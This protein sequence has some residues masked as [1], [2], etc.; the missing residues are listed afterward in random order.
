MIKLRDIFNLPSTPVDLKEDFFTL[1]GNWVPEIDELVPDYDRE[2]AEAIAEDGRMAIKTV[3][4]DNIDGDRYAMLCTV[5]FD[6]KPT[7]IVQEAGR[8]G[9]D[10]FNRWVVDLMTYNEM[11]S[12]LVTKLTNSREAKFADFVDLD[13]DVYPEMFLSF[14]GKNYASN[15][16]LKVEPPLKGVILLANRR[17][18]LNHLSSD[19]YLL[20]TQEYEGDAPEYIRRDSLVMKKVRAIPIEEI[21]EH[22][23]NI[24]QGFIENPRKRVFLY[25]DAALPEGVL[26]QPV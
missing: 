20:F 16:G 24:W 14:Y 25:E 15:F 13:T 11:L 7:L 17:G 26:V 10:Y 5:W 6:S 21:E 1:K 9:R 22:N 2:I 12:Y 4:F 23:K 19:Q 8:S 3:V 18:L